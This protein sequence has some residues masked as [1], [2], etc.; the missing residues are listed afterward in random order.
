MYVAH[1]CTQDPEDLPD[2]PALEGVVLVFDKSVS[3][4][5]QADVREAATAL[6]ATY[7][8]LA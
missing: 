8:T 7:V 3:A 1:C 5:D 4:V 2:L 6:G